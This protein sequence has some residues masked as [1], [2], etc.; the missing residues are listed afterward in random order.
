MGMVSASGEQ[1]WGEYSEIRRVLEERKERGPKRGFFSDS[2]TSQALQRLGAA[3]LKQHQLDA[4]NHQIS[5]KWNLTLQLPDPGSIELTTTKQMLNLKVVQWEDAIESVQVGHDVY[6]DGRR[7]GYRPQKSL[8]ETLDRD[9]FEIKA[10]VDTTSEQAIGIYTRLKSVV[11]I[12]LD[13]LER[14]GDSEEKISAIVRAVQGVAGA[15]EHKYGVVVER[16]S[17]LSLEEKQ[18]VDAVDIYSF[19]TMLDVRVR[20]WSLRQALNLSTD[21]PL[22]KM[23]GLQEALWG[24]ATSLSNVEKTL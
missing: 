12:E 11:Q 24:K 3:V 8:Q 2:D 5:R 17:P 18:H 14:K 20:R 9:F 19:N 6:T 1:A 15:I 23:F 22:S 4:R 10:I 21:S 7:A 13:R 16:S